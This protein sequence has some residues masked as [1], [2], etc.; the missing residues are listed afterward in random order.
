MCF[1]KSAADTQL[2]CHFARLNYSTTDK[3]YIGEK[4]GCFGWKFS[5]G[6]AENEKKIFIDRH[7]TCKYACIV[8]KLLDS[9]LSA[10]SVEKGHHLFF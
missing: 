7:I 9:G 3:Q 1:G 4:F 6:L 2:A 8:C 5:G 10:F